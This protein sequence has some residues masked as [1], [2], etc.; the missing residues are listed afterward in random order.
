VA[1]RDGDL[2]FNIKDGKINR[3]MKSEKKEENSNK[4]NCEDL[5]IKNEEK[6]TKN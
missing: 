4:N 5:M 3:I 1:R 2:R 6:L